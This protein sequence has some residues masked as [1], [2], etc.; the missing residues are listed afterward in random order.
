MFLENSI[1]T[2][3]FLPIV[4]FRSDY[5]ASKA[6]GFPSIGA[7]TFAKYTLID[8]FVS[9]LLI[10]RLSPEI[11]STTFPTKDYSRLFVRDEV[12]LCYFHSPRFFVAAYCDID[13]KSLYSFT[14]RIFKASLESLA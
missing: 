8:S 6:K 9:R 5:F 7:F 12:S 1:S 4:L 10:F 11:I 3:T 13:F 14:S 2:L